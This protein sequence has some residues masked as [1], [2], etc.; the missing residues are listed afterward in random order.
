MDASS[1]SMTIG[2]LA[3]AAGVNVETIR[4]YQRKRLLSEPKRPLGGIRRY[5]R[6]ELARVHFIKAAQRLGFSLDEI[7]ELL[8]LDD[9]THC[10]A[11]RRIAE[12]KLHDVRA[13]LS[14]LQRIESTL[15]GLVTRCGSA[16]GSVKCP[17]IASLRRDWSRPQLDAP[18]HRCSKQEHQHA[19]STVQPG[20]A[21]KLQYPMTAWTWLLPTL[22]FS[23]LV[24]GV[25]LGLNAFFA[26]VCAAALIG[27]VVAAVHHAEVVAHRVGE[28]YGTLVLAVAVTVI[29]ASLILSMML[30]G[31]A[32]AAAL[33]RD[34]IYAAVMIICNGVVGA[35][36]LVGGLAHREQTFRAE[37]SNAGLAALITLA[38]ISLVLPE[39]TTTT[40][41]GTYSNSQLAFTAVGSAVLWAVFVFIQTVRHR[42]YFLPAA[43]ASSTDLHAEPPTSR[44][45]WMS[46]GLLLVSLLAVVGLAKLLS[47][48]MERLIAEAGAPE[49]VLGIAIAMLVPD[50]GDVGGCARGAG[51]PS[52]DQHEPCRWLGGG[53]HRAHHP[54]GGRGRHCIRPA[55]G[56]GSAG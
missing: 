50:A 1:D 33:P 41:R 51:Q 40:P 56:P 22:A 18:W 43:A 44:M 49:A 32:E 4:F 37:G 48:S 47:P 39:F 15:V 23:L 3:D 20:L 11:A 30:A 34:T 6:D 12:H 17:L 14:D 2:V 31:S 21:P 29:E 28:P 54:G 19:L 45:A 36:I 38:T 8:R 53:E 46:F 5:G 25:A 7:G 55:A 24:G 26:V 13:K 42:D 52:A 27:A 35:C 9:G 10:T 16:G